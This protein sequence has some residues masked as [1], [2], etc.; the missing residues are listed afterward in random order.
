MSEAVRLGNIKRHC[1]TSSKPECLR[2]TPRPRLYQ[3]GGAKRFRP[4][5]Y[6]VF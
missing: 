5:A 1:N 6:K 2:S 4:E 3:S